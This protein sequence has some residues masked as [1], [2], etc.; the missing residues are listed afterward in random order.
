MSDGYNPTY[1]DDFDEALREAMA[2]FVTPSPATLEQGDLLV[3]K[4]NENF[5]DNWAVTG[6]TVKFG[7]E[8]TDWS[9]V[10]RGIRLRNGKVWLL[11]LVSSGLNR[12][13]FDIYKLEAVSVYQDA[14][15]ARQACRLIRAAVRAQREQWVEE[16]LSALDDNVHMLAEDVFG[17]D[18][19]EIDAEE[20][21]DNMEAL[22]GASQEAEAIGSGFHVE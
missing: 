21:L 18:D 13:G 10:I 2:N 22:M 4:S 8:R 20:A 15:Q 9:H 14:D 5:S 7:F 6:T 16:S 3:E 12:K 11:E 17:G 19:R 1:G